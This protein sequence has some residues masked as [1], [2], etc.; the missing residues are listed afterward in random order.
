MERAVA[1]Q[2]GGDEPHRWGPRERDVEVH[3][4][5]LPRVDHVGGERRAISKLHSNVME[6]AVDDSVKG[7][8]PAIEFA[9]QIGDEDIA[10]TQAERAAE[11]STDRATSR[12]HES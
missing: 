6:R 12:G 9:A 8:D 4:Q 1:E 10:E 7:D 2:M 5:F 11:S 3:A